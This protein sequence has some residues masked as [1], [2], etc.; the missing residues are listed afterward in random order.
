MSTPTQYQPQRDYQQ[1]SP[2][3]AVFVAAYLGIAGILNVIWGIA[4]LD[5]KAY[6]TSGG[7]LWS[8]LNTWGWIAIV[9]G[10]IQILGAILVAARR[11][12]GAIIAGS[13]AFIG[14]MLNFL[15]IGAYPVWSVIGLVIDSLII[16]AVTVHSDAFLDE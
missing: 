4:A 13:L 16:W 12:G 10:A 14:I 7:L 6:F 2:G 9:V 5:N 1:S 11:A 8:S 3:W 15:S